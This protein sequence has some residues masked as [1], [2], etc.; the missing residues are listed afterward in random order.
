MVEDDARGSAVEA[1]PWAARPD[2]LLRTDLCPSCF[3]PLG[4]LVCGRC[5]LDVRAP[6]AAAV[7]GASRRVVEAIT[8]RD[9]LVAAMRRWSETAARSREAAAVA[10][11]PAVERSVPEAPLPAPP[12][13]LPGAGSTAPE[14]ARPTVPAPPS[15][16]SAA[17]FPTPAPP[18]PALPRRRISVP[19][20][21][22][23]V[24]VVLLSV[25][26]VFY[27]VYAF[28]TYGL[29][30][31]AAITAAVTLAALV[32]AAVLSR[33][34]LPGTAEAVGV[35]GIVLLHLDVWAVRS[36]DLAGAGST[37]PFV[38]FGVGTLVVSAALLVLRPLLRIHAAG[39]AGWAGLTVAAGLLVGAVPSADAGT[40]TALALAAASAVALVHAAP[41]SRG[42]ALPDALE[43]RIL[44]AG[45][46]SAAAL[47][48]LAG[49]LSALDPD[50]VPALPLLVAAAASGAHAWALARLRSRDELH[51]PDR[52]A[53][54]E[55]A[56][57]VDAPFPSTSGGTA[58]VR[59][60]RADDSAPPAPA[61]TSTDPLRVLA[62]AVAGVAAAAAL[63]V[64]ALA[65]GPA[66]L[67]FCAQLAAAAF[68]AAAVDVAA[69]RLR[70]PAVARTARIAAIAALVVTGLAG[71]P[72]AIGGLGGITAALVVGLPAWQ[73]GPLDDPVIALGR[74][75][76]VADLA[77]DVRAA[78]LGLVVVWIIAAGAAILGRRL[79]ARRA[80]L[81][82][83]GA[84][85]LVAAIPSLGPVAV[86]MTAY[87]VASAGALAWRVASRRT[88]GPAAVPAAPLTAL[89][90]AAGALA[91]AAS[92]AST[93][94]WWV[95]TPCI[96][97]LLVAASRT[98][99]TDHTARL[100]TVGA[101]LAGL[102]AAAG[103][104]PSLTAA[105][106]ISAEPVTTAL[107]S[108]AD[109]VVLVLLASALGV[110][111]T[112]ALPGLPR[113]RRRALLATLLLPAC[114]TALTVALVGA[115]RV[116]GALTA[117]P[118]WS[119]SAQVVLA[120]GV[121]A[122]TV[123]GARGV[124]L[125]ARAGRT[126]E[127]SVAARAP[128]TTALRRWR[129]T[130]AAL[131]APILLL[132]ILTA[133][134]MF[135][136][137]AL[138]HGV[139]PAAVAVVV[140]AGSL[141]AYRHASPSLRVALD[142]GTAVVATG[143]LIVAVSVD[144]TR[145]AREL[146]W[147]P[148]LLI[149]GTALV[150]SVAHDGLLLS[151][152]ARRAWA[153]TALALGISAL[154][155]RLLAGGT[156]SSEAYWL[157]V[158][159]VL[160][161]VAASIHRAAVRVDGAAHGPGTPDGPPDGPPVRFGVW[162]LTLAGILTAVL[163]L[164][165]VGRPEDVLRPYLLTGICAALALGASAA[166]RGA[167][168]PVRPLL[169]AVVI[170]GGIGLLVVGGTRALRLAAG[171]LDRAPT[172][173]LQL[174]ITA[175]LL[176][177]VGILVLRGAR[178]PGDVLL[179]GSA[180]TAASALVTV[181][182]S[183]SVG[184]GEGVVRP[185]VASVTLVAGA[186]A[187]LMIRSVHRRV[188]A[189]SA[190]VALLG[191]V[192]VA[193]V[194]WRGGDVALDPAAL[195]VPAIVAV[196]V[197]A[198]GAA[199][200]LRHPAPSP[201]PGR[202]SSPIDDVLRHSADATTLALVAGTAAVGAASDGPGLPVALLLSGVAVLVASIP[203]G[204]RARRLVGWLALALGSA[205]LWVALGRGGVDAVE[206]YVLPPAGV[207][208]VVAAGLHRGVPG[209]RRVSPPLPARASGAA[210]VLLGALL[211]AAL[212]TAVA[213]WTG[214][215]VRA[216]VLGAAAGVVLLLAAT[217]LRGTDSAAPARPLLLATAAAAG[218]AVPV[219]GFGR[220]LGQMLASEPATF[221]RT[222]LWTLAAAVVLVLAVGLLPA[223]EAEPDARLELET[224]A[225]VVRAGGS[226]TPVTPAVGRTVAAETEPRDAAAHRH[227]LVRVMPRV[228]VLVALVGVGTVGA[229][230]I[231]RAHA[232]GMHDGGPRSAVL[233]GLI[234]AIHVAC[235]PSRTSQEMTSPDGE[236]I[237][238]EDAAALHDRV[239][240][241][242]ALVAGGLVGAVL[243]ATGAADPAETVSVPIA[244]ALLLVGTRRLV[245]DPPA[246]S[247]RHLSPGLLVL[248]V[249]PLLADLGPSPAWRIV[250]L[251]IVALATLLTGARLRLRA[252][253][254]IGAVVLFLH[255]IAQ[256]W[257]WIREA[258]ATVPW[259]AWAGI[260]GVVLI[261]VA[262][263]YEQ[264]IRDVKGMAARVSSL[265]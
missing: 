41:R 16:R 222:D 109:P 200:R 8:E 14:A 106:V 104:A 170:G 265:R 9:R 122:W 219:V 241:L 4:A 21:L 154:W 133:S 166:L 34:R 144:P 149:A 24:G 202:A 189:A 102:I 54:A 25:A 135:D 75:S 46:V 90:L 192:L 186:G 114:L 243:F 160:L 248:L 103:L 263:R 188:L 162:A 227:S 110:L 249:P 171:Y 223:R 42:S 113:V 231:L 217:A 205:A 93:G 228:A 132:T 119:I 55:Q 183:A 70:D 138:P 77:T 224:R 43:R 211:L 72:A 121:V 17:G 67:T 143:S 167:A 210:P 63:P 19:A 159:G 68:A 148:L 5:G 116:G 141:L 193:F 261:A 60:S 51:L 195:A 226:P 87:L 78:A 178:S 57:A 29:V 203:P 129:L 164:A 96:V 74:T 145:G 242:A 253:F 111:V 229:A 184:S 94:T 179:A 20:V 36:Y 37:D 181:V 262:A 18:A 140:A 260:G 139:V 232:E 26:A 191:A 53:G 198:V 239:L 38:H 212:P 126:D 182:V 220:A 100:A 7:L 35:V 40:R 99:R 209:L 79:R 22:L 168:A 123:G 85:A 142:V 134:G 175:A 32:V 247:M 158:A 214:T 251:G 89:S 44:R 199:D 49:A 157:P 221:G 101:A 176:V 136:R 11:V 80:L 246:G 130:T 58:D 84:A 66:L 156:T 254:L 13:E 180:W 197:A 97:L 151:R 259:W 233:V 124:P 15:Q 71:L 112:G 56:D 76:D 98:A 225:S 250:G 172:V 64:T 95:A 153:W 137:G 61:P 23:A 52:D 161:L 105:R 155:S 45:G 264:R 208:L 234:A 48:V 27:V 240:G 10:A 91:W 194:A 206:P 128:G 118:V 83:T 177:G 12:D 230:G 196:L 185:L 163:P 125:P 82:W 150:L 204:S 62:A 173:D 252:P 152:S 30:V 218:L 236:A 86:V 6:E 120:A 187:L 69:R 31:R 73:R 39:I 235:S 47:A 256:L 81:A 65:G 108:A 255:A 238:C 216:L 127:E 117:S 92:W 131:V 169:R 107:Q 33:R 213:S 1:Q 215:P 190:A 147:V 28:V 88:P 146:L 2:D 174:A 258:S 3:S 165:A 115:D 237:P 245:R 50:A 207:M 244:A 201:L 59:P 257:P